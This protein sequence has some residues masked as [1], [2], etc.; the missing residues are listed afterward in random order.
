MLSL[1][2][3]SLPARWGATWLLLCLPL[4]CSIYGEELLCGDECGSSEPSSGGSGIASGGEASLG[5]SDGGVFQTGD[6][7]AL[8]SDGGSPSSGGTGGLGGDSG[9]GGAVSSLCSTHPI[10][11]RANWVASASRSGE[12]D[13]PGQAVDASLSS[14]WSTGAPMNSLD[15]WRVDF[16]GP[17]AITRVEIYHTEGDQA[18]RYEVVV[19]DE[20]PTPE[21]APILTGTN[22]DA[23]LLELHFD[24][25]VVGRYFFIQQIG[26]EEFQWW[27]V[28]EVFFSCVE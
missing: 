20:E 22:E 14:R 10:P 3:R 24:Q 26:E 7:G 5:G 4:G 18:R 12:V 27:S 16:G 13:P 11:A 1:W 25:P 19:A 2:P 8:E 9:T 28:R 21:T 23:E 15:F 6:G 17:V